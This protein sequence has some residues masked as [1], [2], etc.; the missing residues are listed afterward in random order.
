MSQTFGGRSDDSQRLVDSFSNLQS[1]TLSAPQVD[2]FLTEVAALA[3]RLD[4]RLSASITV[5]ATAGGRSAYTAA[6]SDE[7]ALGLDEMQY[8]E[9]AGPCLRTARTGDT[10]L[11]EDVTAPGDWPAYRLAAVAAGVKTSMSVPLSVGGSTIGGL[12]LY[13]TAPGTFDAA[14]QDTLTVFT[15]QA[16]AALAMVL[17]HDQQSQIAAQLEQALSSRAVIDQALGILMAQQRCTV[18]QAFALLRARSQSSGRKV[19]DLAA[20]LIERVTGEPPTSGAPFDRGH[21]E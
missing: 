10:T 20:D 8:G 9:D 17:R 12:N 16:A 3:A 14:L 7:L 4:T 19:R 2:V 6:F 13:G 21:V 1:L 11:V 15:A 18:D 5:T